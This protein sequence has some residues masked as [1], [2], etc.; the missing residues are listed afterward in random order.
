MIEDT[1]FNGWDCVRLA[2]EEAE[3]VVPKNI[4]P[5][6]VRCGL[7]DGANLFAEKKDEAG[8]RGEAH[9]CIRGGHRLWHSPEDTKRT[10]ALDNSPVDIEAAGNRLVIRQPVEADTGMRKEIRIE[11]VNAR[12]FKVAHRISNEGLWPVEFSVWA[13]S[14]MRHGGY[15]A[16]PLLPKESHEGNL[17][18]KYHMVPWTYT[19]F[20]EAA[21]QWHRDFIGIDVSKSRI[22]QKLGLSNYPGWSAYWQEAGTFVLAA[23]VESGARYPDFGCA[24]ETFHCDW[25]IELETLSPLRKVA[26]GETAEHVEFWGV[27]G[28]IQKFD[29]DKA[30]TESLVPAVEAWRRD[31]RG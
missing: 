1:V 29:T 9:W 19:D 22:P 15:A 31:I 20:S 23:A 27:L 7:K 13:L 5:R 21:W 4:G 28:S 30:Y 25:M 18:P 26:P 24:F 14:V 12:T 8:G 6:V 3:L 10:Y 2:T 11:A 17:L 16:I